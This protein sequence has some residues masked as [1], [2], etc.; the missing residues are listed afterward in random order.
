MSNQVNRFYTAV[1][2]LAGHGL[3]KQRLIKAFEDNLAHIDDD[4]IPVSA[5]ESFSAVTYSMTLSLRL[6]DHLH[7]PIF[8]K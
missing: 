2:V 5:R 4:A 8:F 3:I 7:F 1:S 6:S